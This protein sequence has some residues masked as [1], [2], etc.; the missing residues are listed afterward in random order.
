MR[1]APLLLLA[2]CANPPPVGDLDLVVVGSSAITPSSATMA[3]DRLILGPCAAEGQAGSNVEILVGYRMNLL[4]PEP[5][6]VPV[7]TYCRLGL[8]L[9]ADPFD[10]SLRIGG[11]TAMGTSF[12]LALDPGLTV[13]E[14]EVPYTVDTQGI[15]ALD[16]ALL[17]EPSDV[18][19]LDAMGSPAVVS[20]DDALAEKLAEQVGDALVFFD[21]P[22]EAAATYIDLWP[23]FDFSISA[24]LTVEGCQSGAPLAADPQTPHTEPLNGGD[25]G[26]ADTSGEDT[27][28]GDTSDED[29]SEAPVEPPAGCDGG[30]GCGSG[31]GCQ[32]RS[33]SACSGSDCGAGCSASCATGNFVPVGWA[34]FIAFL[35]HRRRPRGSRERDR[36]DVV[37]E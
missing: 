6:P 9:A 14:H 30:S 25:T 29:T 22:Q 17:F 27:G 16:L 11:T 19:A 10:G 23:D 24:R 18:D 31:S 32:G 26:G 37:H 8:G 33:G 15:L 13:R 36:R 28:E 12:T 4:R 1:V 35:A 21:S 20:P 2:A 7:D 3:L 34:A 5:L